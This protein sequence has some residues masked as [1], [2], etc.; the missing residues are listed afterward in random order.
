MNRQRETSY[1]KN[2]T[3]RKREVKTNRERS[4]KIMR[5]RGI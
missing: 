1:R 5:L 2:G 4:E 3:K